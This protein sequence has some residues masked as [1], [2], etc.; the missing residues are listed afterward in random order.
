M[1]DIQE[2]LEKIDKAIES[3]QSCMA[4]VTD[5]DLEGVLMNSSDMFARENEVMIG[6]ETVHNDPY[7]N[8]DIFKGKEQ[9]SEEES[10]KI[11]KYKAFKFCMKQSGLGE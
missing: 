2:Y 1:A 9:M 6:E 5:Q 3:F 7:L 4:T 11:R 10:E 8:F